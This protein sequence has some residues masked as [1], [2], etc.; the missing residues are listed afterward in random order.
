MDDAVDASRA[1]EGAETPAVTSREEDSR[2]NASTTPTG[3]ARPVGD[4]GV[5]DD[6]DG[7]GRAGTTSPETFALGERLDALDEEAELTVESFLRETSRLFATTD[8]GDDDGVVRDRCRRGRRG[9]RRRAN[10]RG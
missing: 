8:D 9:E 10:G 3:T 7:R 4:D 2:A 6:D 5:D 1:R